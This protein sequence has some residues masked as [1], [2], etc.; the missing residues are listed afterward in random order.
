MAT[1]TIFANF[2]INDKERFLR[3]KDSFISFKNIEARKWVINVRG[4]YKKDV[5]SFLYSHLGEKLISYD[6]ESDKGWFHDTKR[7]LK[8]IDTDFVFFWVEDHINLVGVQKYKEILNEMKESESEYLLYSWWNFGKSR[9]IY[10]VLQKKE[11][12]NISTF[13][14]D[15]NAWSKIDKNKIYLISMVSFLSVDLFKKIIKKGPPTL[16]G[17]SKFCPF[18]FEKGG[19]DTEWLPIRYA[20]SKCELFA[21]VDDGPEGYSLQSRGLYPC[22]VLRQKSNPRK[23]PLWKSFFRAKIRKY[24]PNFIYDSL[25]KIIIFLNRVMVYFSLIVKGR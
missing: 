23:V 20:L 11:F 21:S 10:D 22:R 4:V 8:D 2:Q 12:N 19:A 3:L 13:L 18:D 1:L 17:Y 6:L 25:I 16:R 7:M 5:L 9:E 14:F 15:F 24:I